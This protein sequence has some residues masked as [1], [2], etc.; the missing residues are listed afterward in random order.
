[1][2]FSQDGKTESESVFERY[3]QAQGLK[4]MPIPTSD[5]KQPDYKVEHNAMICVFEVKEFD[6]PDPKPSGGYSPCPPI[7][8]K[9]SHGG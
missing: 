3:L 7:R 4:W 8:A 1:M 5:Q 2:S 9:D 6:D